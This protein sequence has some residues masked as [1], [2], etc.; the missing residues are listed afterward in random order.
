M[1]GDD[2]LDPSTHDVARVAA[3]REAVLSLGRECEWHSGHAA[4]VSRL[5]LVLYRLLVRDGA[6]DADVFRPGPAGEWLEHSALLHDI[7]YIVDARKHHKHAAQL[8]RDASLPGFFAFEIEI[9]ALVAR[10]HRKR[11]PSPDQKV[12]TGLGQGVY[13]VVRALSA[14]L[15]VA[16][17]LDRSHRS[18]VE[19]LDIA[20]N[21][22]RLEIGLTVRG[23]TDV[24][25]WA[26]ECKKSLLEEVV[27]ARVAIR[28]VAFT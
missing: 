5:A 4:Q 23:N 14:V 18:V 10:F 2:R 3:R 27:G 16:D 22:S 12:F 25:V 26:A 17:G 21:L 1:S 15:R 11:S 13:E 28:P 6:I 20:W 8:I 7:G 19:T 9:I 24:E